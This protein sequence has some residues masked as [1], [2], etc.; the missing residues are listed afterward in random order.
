MTISE[1]TKTSTS[2]AYSAPARLSALPVVTRSQKLWCVVLGALFAFDVIDIYSFSYAAPAITREWGL[3]LHSVGAVTSA[4]FLGMFFGGITGGRISDRV[5]RKTTIIGAVMVYSLFSLITTFA[6]TVGFLVIARFLTGFGLQA[7]TGVLIV[8]VAEMFPRRF[9]GRYQSLLLAFGLVGVPIAA[10]LA[11][12]VISLGPGMWRWVFVLG[13]L[14]ALVGVAAIWLLPESVRWQSLRGDDHRANA[15]VAK[16]EAQAK[17]K[18]RAPLPAPIEEPPVASGRVEEL[19]RG[20]NLR[21]FIVLCTGS[22]LVAFA[23][24]G[25]NA[26]VPILLVDHGYTTSQTLLFAS[27]F[28]IAAVPG[29]LLAWPVVDRFE[30]KLLIAGM[31]VVVGVLFVVF[32]VTSAS[33]LVLAAGFIISMFLQTQTVFL[34]AYLPEMF[35]THLRG[36][37]SGIA[38]GLGRLGVFAGGFIFAPLVG[39]A[40]F[41][42]YFITMAVILVAGGAVT[43]VFGMRSTN[44]PLVENTSAASPCT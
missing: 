29:A 26:Y 21:N 23:F 1:P 6:N 41:S 39:A 40:G 42:G 10:W 22:V 44:R 15:T 3:S 27:I 38:N 17:A 24:F 18:T 4:T 35:P 7:M 19:L 12:L 9:R 25:Y 28:S 31:T 13:A 34:Y 14:G 36:V 37:G 32:G 33:G 5:G 43:G 2:A 20:R 11:R 30:R 8:Y 16:L